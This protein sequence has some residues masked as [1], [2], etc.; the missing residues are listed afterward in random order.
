MMVSHIIIKSLIV[1]E[2]FS[3]HDRFKRPFFYLKQ[4]NSD[5]LQLICVTTNF[6]GED[7][8]LV[9]KFKKIKS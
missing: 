7:G 6:L 2:L 1:C 5:S 3:F 8:H 9:F 4:K